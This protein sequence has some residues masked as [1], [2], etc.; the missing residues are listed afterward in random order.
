MRLRS[1][2]D[3]AVRPFD[4]RATPESFLLALGSGFVAS[5]LHECG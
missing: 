5:V 3:T 4:P 2:R 1:A